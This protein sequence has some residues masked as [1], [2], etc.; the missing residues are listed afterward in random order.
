MILLSDISG[1][2]APSLSQGEPSHSLVMGPPEPTWGTEAELLLPEVGRGKGQPLSP[3]LVLPTGKTTA[4]DSLPV[5]LE[6][7]KEEIRA[8]QD[9]YQ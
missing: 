3:L 5:L 9:F 6:H 4:D 7:R 8:K 1:Q 2:D